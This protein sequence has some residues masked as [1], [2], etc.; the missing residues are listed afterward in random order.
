MSWRLLREGGLMIFDDYDR[1]KVVRDNVQRPMPA[2]NAFII[3]NKASLDLIHRDY[4]V[5]IR[6]RAKGA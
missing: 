4:Q 2:I 3:L 5:I 1:R 6:K